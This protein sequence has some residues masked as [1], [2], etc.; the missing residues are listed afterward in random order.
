[1][2]EYENFS[3]KLSDQLEVHPFGKEDYLLHETKLNRRIRVGSLTKLII[4][5][6]DGKQNI[7]EIAYSINEAHQIKIDTD[8]IHN[9]LY[10]E[11]SKYGIVESD[12]PVKGKDP[13]KYLSPRITL[14][15]EKHVRKVSHFLT[16]LFK[17]NFFYT[18]LAFLTCFM[19]VNY[20]YF[21]PIFD[22]DRT[23]SV[24]LATNFFIL[25]VFSLF[26]HELGH[27]SACR[28]FGAR[29]GVIGFGFYML[30]PVL[31]ADVS[32]AWKLK[33][34]QRIIID[35][36]GFYM[37]A[38]VNS[39][40]LVVFI[41]T[42]NPIYL[43]M[44]TIY[45]IG[46]FFNLN[47]FFR[48]DGYWVL[49][50]ALGIP[51]LQTNATKKMRNF[52]SNFIRKK[53]EPLLKTN[54]DYFLLIYGIVSWAFIFVMLFLILIANPD[55]ILKFPINSFSF[56]TEIVHT[57]PNVEYEWLKDEFVKLF[58]PAVFYI[59]IFKLIIRKL[60]KN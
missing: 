27:A 36:A 53:T 10:D 32:D 9:I 30:S 34:S 1:M 22:F 50:D 42:N 19:V 59:M 24:E 33:A 12:S 46:M 51:N 57:L 3:P 14:F 43:S 58:L 16:F 47:P 55:S 18:S 38:I 2:N 7:K 5:H 60:T 54:K 44:A 37:Q 17:P 56:I 11:L 41:I 31:Y 23:I 4:D 45:L 26:L 13:A 39:G 6:V 20:A 48:R 29:H 49:S 25:N 15:R 52:F 8:R 35:L 28:S 40:L 21:L